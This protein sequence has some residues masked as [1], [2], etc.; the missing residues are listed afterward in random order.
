VAANFSAEA[1]AEIE[2]LTTDVVAAFKVRLQANPWMSDATR[3]KALEKLAKMKVRVGYP[4]RWASYAATAIGPSYGATLRNIATAAGQANFRAVG[5]PVDNTNWGPVAEVNAFYDPTNNSIT[6]P[7]GILQAPFFDAAADPASN[8]G[9]IGYVIGHEITHGFDL[10]GSQF[11]GDGKLAP[12][13]T[14]ADRAKFVAINEQLIAQYSKLSIGPGLNVDGELTIGENAAD[15]GG[16]QSAFDAMNARLATQRVGLIDD[17]SQQQRFFV[18]AAQVWRSKQ[19]P[20]YAKYLLQVDP[21]SPNDIR[22]VQ[23]SR[24]MAA[25]HDAFSI[26][27][28]DKMYLDPA[29]RV[30]LW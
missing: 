24:N 29:D 5:Q 1:K 10:G 26:V 3:T 22:A 21:H 17:L 9:A 19:Q 13:F 23:P 28:G 20:E 7:A 6:F 18:A 4:D 25:F 11:D 16:L 15:L 14:D 2:R 12:W 27:S 8:Y 30:T